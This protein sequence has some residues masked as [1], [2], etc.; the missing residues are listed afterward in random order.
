MPLA[1][2]PVLL[3]AAALLAVLLA[4]AGR[5]GPHR[6]ELYFVAA[7]RRLA[8]GYPDQPPLTPLLARLADEVAPGSVVALHVVAA[9]MVALVVVVAALTAR[10]LGA[11]RAAQV[12]TAVTVATGGVTAVLGHMLST[13]TTDLLLSAVV[14]WLVV[15]VLM[16]DAPRGW[17]LVGLAAGLGLQ[18]KHLVA[19]L[20][21][22]VVVGVVVTPAV[23]H[24]LGSPWAWGGVAVALAVWAPNLAWQAAH[25]WPQLALASDIRQEYGTVE[26]RAGFVL[27]LVVLLSPVATA[28]AGY[29]AVRLWRVPELR[30]ARPVAVAAAVLLVAYLVT[31]GKAYYLAGLLPALVAAGADGL[32]RRGS[33]ARARRTGVVLALAGLVAAPATLPLLPASVFGGS[34]LLDVNEDGG[35]TVGWPELVGTTRQVVAD[36]GAVLVLTANYGEAGALELYGSDVP[37]V[38]GHN[39][40]GDWGPP[41]DTLTGPV[42]VLGYDAP[43]PWLEGCAEVGHVRNSAGVENEEHGKPVLVCAGPTAPWSEVWPRVRRLAA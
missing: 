41:P 34:F 17:L 10:E 14:L 19:L 29:G 36:T 12:L 11:G 7:G 30:A 24:H 35:E 31:G 32:V 6:D 42:V 5:Y 39:G 22:A 43:P 3:T 21:A 23:R 9:V 8:W 15:R 28:V 27:L 18:N 20:L 13:A 4:L 33:P 40:Y 25:G 38:S 16:R 1:T 37:V 2:R 26:E